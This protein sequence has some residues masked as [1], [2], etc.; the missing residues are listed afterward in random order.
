MGPPL[1]GTDGTAVGRSH[2]CGMQRWPLCQEQSVK[3]CAQ[4]IVD[5]VLSGMMGSRG[6]LWAV[7]VQSTAWSYSVSSKNKWTLSI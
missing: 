3:F 6:G 4:A 7:R 5:V 2:K 1:W